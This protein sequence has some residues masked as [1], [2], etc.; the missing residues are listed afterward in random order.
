MPETNLKPCP[1]CGGRPE[2]ISCEVDRD[3]EVH[4]VRCKEPDCCGRI[5][6]RWANLDTAVYAWNKRAKEDR[7]G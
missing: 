7:H 6:R 2:V 3:K 5:T 4:M 1:F